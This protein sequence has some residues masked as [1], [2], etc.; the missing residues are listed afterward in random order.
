VTDFSTGDEVMIATAR[1]SPIAS[2]SLPRIGAWSASLSIHLAIIAL[3]L[4]AP[5]AIRLV[6]LVKA[7]QQTFVH[8]IDP[9]PIEVQPV[10]LLPVPVHHA[11]APTV[12]HVAPV[13]A[14]QPE[15]TAASQ[16][17]ENAL[18]VSPAI[19]SGTE[20]S[21]PQDVAPSAIAYGSKT[22]V[23]YPTEA[24]RRHEQGTVILR[25][26]VDAEGKVLTVEIETSSGSPRLDRAARDAV[27]SWSFNPAKHGG[28]ALSA[29][30]RV[31][32]SFNLSTL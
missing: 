17:R 8:F 2:L 19:E 32:V 3:L 15:N 31:P 27:K 20:S 12:H 18:P 5:A 22:S 11:A 4:S 26:L 10:P 6:Q 30:A 23:P 16:A 7:D 24:L 28:V 9:K 14:V 29:W 13:I 1:M 25:V 21:A